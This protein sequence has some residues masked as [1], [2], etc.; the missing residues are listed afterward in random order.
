M[1]RYLR[2]SLIFLAV[3]AGCATQPDLSYESRPDQVILYADIQP[4][5]GLPPPNTTCRYLFV[6]QSIRYLVSNRRA[7]EDTRC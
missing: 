2:I 5:A 7:F 1:L 6:P 4:I 3:V